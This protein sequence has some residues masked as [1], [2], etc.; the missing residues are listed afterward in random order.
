MDSQD[1]EKIVRVEPIE[2]LLSIALDDQS[3]EKQVKV[4]S[5]LSPKEANELTKNLWQNVNVFAW[6]A[7][8]MLGIFLEVITHQLNASSTCCPMRQKK[9]HL[10]PER[11]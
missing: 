1:K 5:R 4:S 3:L 11:A 9:M 6:S 7:A 10:D 8:D 2:E